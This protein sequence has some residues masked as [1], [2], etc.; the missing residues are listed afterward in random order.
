MDIEVLRKLSYV[1]LVIIISLSLICLAS[2]IWGRHGGHKKRDKTLCE[3]CEG[4]PDII[5]TMCISLI[6]R[7]FNSK[8]LHLSDCKQG[9]WVCWRIIFGFGIWNRVD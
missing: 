7:R 3:S 9:I 5:K 2:T 4:L 6:D 8:L 1:L